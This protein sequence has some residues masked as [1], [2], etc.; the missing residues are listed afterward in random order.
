MRS[1]NID[2]TI[3]YIVNDEC[4]GI[5]LKFYNY[6]EVCLEAL[7]SKISSIHT[8]I[9]KKISSIEGDEKL[10][11]R[12][13]HA[14]FK[15]EFVEECALDWCHLQTIDSIER[16]FRKTLHTNCHRQIPFTKYPKYY[17]ELKKKKIYFT[18]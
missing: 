14:L 8:K 1:L 3:S 16:D 17:I 10:T 5:D 7:S 18:C 2:K 11:W 4:R 13:Y 9:Y 12:K 6:K 15:K